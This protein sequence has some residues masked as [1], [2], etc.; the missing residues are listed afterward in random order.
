MIAKRI[1]EG[2]TDKEIAIE[3]DIA[4]GTVAVHNKRIFKKLNIHSRNELSA[5]KKQNPPLK[6]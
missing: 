4:P 6:N 3:L 2:K 5:Q 1:A